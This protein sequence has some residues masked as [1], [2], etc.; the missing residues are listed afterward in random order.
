MRLAVGRKCRL[1]IYAVVALSV[2]AGSVSSSMARSGGVVAPVN[3]AAE[4]YPTATVESYDVA[5][6]NGFL[7]HVTQTVSAPSFSATPPDER[8]QITAS[9]QSVAAGGTPESAWLTVTN[10]AMTGPGVPVGTGLTH[11]YRRT[12]RIRPTRAQDNCPVTYVNRNISD[13]YLRNTSSWLAR[14]GGAPCSFTSGYMVFVAGVAWSYCGGGEWH[15]VSI[16]PM[17]SEV[18][19]EVGSSFY[20]YCTQTFHDVVPGQAKDNGVF[21]YWHG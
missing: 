18:T 20:E 12:G 19:A 17:I 13:G 11:A 16:S 8:A 9:V 14:A 1:G 4:D 2:F 6:A 7:V 10:I 3:L 21:T 5:G 15:V